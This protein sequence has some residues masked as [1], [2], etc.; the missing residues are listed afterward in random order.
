MSSKA[1]LSLNNFSTEV[2]ENKYFRIQGSKI[3][4]D[5]KEMEIYINATCK[6]NFIKH[7]KFVQFR[8]T[9]N[10]ISNTYLI[11]ISIALSHS[12]SLSFSLL[13]HVPF[14]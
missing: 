11:F 3:L 6:G 2:Y 14:I 1:E 4:I 8:I 5:L 13:F 12:L 10:N 7:L 9:Y